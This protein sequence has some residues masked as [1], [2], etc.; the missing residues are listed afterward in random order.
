MCL[1]SSSSKRAA[2]AF[3]TGVDSNSGPGSDG[4]RSTRTEMARGGAA[5]GTLRRNRVEEIALRIRRMRC[6]LNAVSCKEDGSLL[7]VRR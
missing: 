5:L 1:S 7:I 6:I 3:P 4:N 2:R